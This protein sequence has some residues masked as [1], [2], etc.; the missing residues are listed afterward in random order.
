MFVELGRHS[1]ASP[2]GFDRCDAD[3]NPQGSLLQLGIATSSQGLLMLVYS[4]VAGTSKSC[5][6]IE[7]CKRGQILAA[8]NRFGDSS[9]KT[10]TGRDL[11]DSRNPWPRS[12]G[13]LRRSRRVP[14]CLC[15]A[16]GLRCRK[17]G[18]GSPRITK[19]TQYFCMPLKRCSC[20]SILQHL[21]TQ[22]QSLVFPSPP[23]T[24]SGNCPEGKASNSTPHVRPVARETGWDSCLSR[25]LCL[26]RLPGERT[27]SE[28]CVRRGDV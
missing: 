1:K 25:P 8:P 6:N 10:A 16:R 28:A 27:F 5:P 9:C 15:E 21:T 4:S 13:S 20:F 14:R 2:A 26:V 7:I 11:H 17:Q 19:E 23:G 18:S 24:Q 3:D 12:P 22:Y